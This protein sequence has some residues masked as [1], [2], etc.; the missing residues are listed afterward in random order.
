VAPGEKEKVMLVVSKAKGRHRAE[1]EMIKLKPKRVIAFWADEAKTAKVTQFVVTECTGNDNPIVLGVVRAFKG[2]LVM[3]KDP[4]DSYNALKQVDTDCDGESDFLDIDDDDDGIPDADDLD[5]DNNGV[6]DDDEDMNTDNDKWPDIVDC[7]DDNDNQ[8]DAED[9]DDDDDGVLDVDE[10]DSDGD[11]VEDDMDPDDDNDGVADELDPD[12]DGDGLPDPSSAND[13]C[14][15]NNDCDPRFY[16]AKEPGDCEGPGI[17]APTPVGYCIEIY[18]PVCG[19][20]GNTYPNA[21]YAG[22][23]GVNVAYEGVCIP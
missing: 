10:P 14:S 21:C 8:I 6:D 16:C 22:L 23:A 12:D 2:K 4:N 11:G 15:N 1:P 19:C 5:D 18:S 3:A 20:D 13:E 7:D 9:P 17:C